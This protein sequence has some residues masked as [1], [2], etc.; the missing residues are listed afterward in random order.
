[1]SSDIFFCSGRW[2]LLNN[3][4]HDFRMKQMAGRKK[5]RLLID[6]IIFILLLLAYA[7]Y[8]VCNT[9][10]FVV[11]EF[12]EFLLFIIRCLFG[13]CHVMVNDDERTC[14]ASQSGAR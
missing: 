2:I 10:I 1:M 8:A 12:I 9:W 11:R 14:M 3:A 5:N 4:K 13:F 6:E 7:Q